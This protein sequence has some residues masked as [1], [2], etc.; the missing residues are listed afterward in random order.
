M[1]E[2]TQQNLTSSQVL[3]DIEAPS[4]PPKPD[5][6][7]SS[8]GMIL[9]LVLAATALFWLLR[10]RSK[11]CL[12]KRLQWLREQE[13]DEQHLWQAFDI[14]QCLDRKFKQSSAYQTAQ[15][16]AL[17]TSL[18]EAASAQKVEVSRE[19]FHLYLNQLDKALS[20]SSYLSIPL[21]NR[22]S[23]RTTSREKRS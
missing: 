1:P 12:R 14:W 16:R 13:V 5:A 4:V 21:L 3:L 11:V 20:V 9:L 6:G 2:T 23:K 15:W 8:V 22:F 18:A 17:G 10:R 19:T 7:F